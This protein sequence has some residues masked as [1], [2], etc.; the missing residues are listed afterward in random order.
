[1]RL[2]PPSMALTLE[3]LF[4]MLVDWLGD[5]PVL[6]VSLD[7]VFEPPAELAP[8]DCSKRAALLDSSNLCLRLSTSD[9][10]LS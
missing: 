1:M 5:T 9:S 4:S 3:P 7:G 6:G 10:S 8:P 2:R